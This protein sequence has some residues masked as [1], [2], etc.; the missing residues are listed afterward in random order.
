[1]LLKTLPNPS[2][3]MSMNLSQQ[4]QPSWDNFKSK[5]FYYFALTQAKRFKIPASTIIHWAEWYEFSC[6][7][8][9]VLHR[10]SPISLSSAF[11]RSENEKLYFECAPQKFLVKRK[12]SSFHIK[13]LPPNCSRTDSRV[14]NTVRR[15]HTH[16]FFL[17]GKEEEKV[18][19]LDDYVCWRQRQQ[20][21]NLQTKAK[22][23]IDEQ[24]SNRSLVEIRLMKNL[25]EE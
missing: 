23:N 7:R 11:G 15:L 8:N 9:N 20:D 16:L 13:F 3:Q 18:I 22:K 19:K 21:E 2:L 17:R 5:C 6:L 24:T 10:Q 14:F 4:F 12:S 25:S 1:M